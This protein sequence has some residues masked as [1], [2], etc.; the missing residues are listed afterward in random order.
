M[1]QSAQS[2]KL[3]FYV[4][5]DQIGCAKPLNPNFKEERPQIENSDFESPL[6]SKHSDADEIKL[7]VFS[8]H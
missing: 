3:S 5:R 2:Q 4:H 7:T 1:L 8:S 6:L